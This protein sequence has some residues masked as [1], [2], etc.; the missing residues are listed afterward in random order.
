MADA[1]GEAH[2]L[3]IVHRDL[4][5]GNVIVTKAGVKLL[6]FGLAKLH[7]VPSA[8]PGVSTEA[9]Q[10]HP[11]TD[12]ATILG[13]WQYMSPEQLEGKAVDARTDIF[14][15]GAVLYEM[16][17]GRKAFAG[18][19]QASLIAAILDHDP[20]AVSTLRG[21]APAALDR[22]V[23][24]CLSKDREERWQT[25]RDVRRA[26][27]AIAEDA[28]RLQ[29]PGAAAGRQA[30]WLAATVAI[31]LVVIAVAGAMIWSALSARRSQGPASHLAIPLD[32]GAPYFLGIPSSLAIS[33]DGRHI[34]YS[35]GRQ[36]SLSLYHRTLDQP[37]SSRLDATDGAQSPFFSPDGE[38][39]G[40]FANGRLKKVR[41][42]AGGGVVTICEAPGFRGAT[43]GGRNTIVFAPRPAS[44]LYQVS[45]DGGTA[46]PLTTR[47]PDELSHRNPQFLPDG[48]TVLFTVGTSEITSWDEARIEA[49]AT[50]TGERHVVLEGSGFARYV[51]SGHL[52]FART[53]NLFALRFDE[54]AGRAAGQPVRIASNVSMS[55]G[56][57]V[58]FAVSDA[59]VLAYVSSD[60]LPFRNA[61]HRLEWIDRRGQQTVI[62]DE[63][64]G[65]FLPRVSP[66]GTRVVVQIAAP[67]NTLWVADL[68]RDAALTR[69]MVAG[70]V[71]SPVWRD[72]SRLLYTA[73]AA[74]PEEGLFMVPADG[75]Q[76]ERRLATNEEPTYFEDV[77]RDGRLALATR[78]SRTTRQDIWV[79]PLEGSASPTAFLHST[80][81]EF[82]A[83][84]S[85]DGRW[86]AYVSNEAGQGQYHVY[87]RA[88]PGGGE[89]RQV[90]TERAAAVVWA[91]SGREL[92]YRER[93]RNRIM[94][95][96]IQASTHL[97]VGGPRPLFELSGTYAEP[98]DIAPDG[99]RFLMVRWR[100]PQ[101]PTHISVVVNWF[102][103]LNRLAPQTPH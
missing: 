24:D 48:R 102:E 96:Q 42:G 62:G 58:E 8:A 86:L 63:E 39:V 89:R 15:F 60:V 14:A 27:E 93:E 38:W 31:A 34:V 36:G 1:L 67:S 28:A 70:D 82:G 50:D 91:P 12:G 44:G 21:D 16:L 61:A 66:G 30:R 92:F 71:N 40:F 5:P 32:T 56:A 100:E 94:A 37:I 84:L 41:L 95:V 45:A 20:P 79:I 35:A 6:D 17:T 43:W 22:I 97:V 11:L 47:G 88:F 78:T 85:P 13:T 74:P 33:P 52:V 69:V 90:S 19:S 57:N 68:R 77:S 72:D 9:P 103:E 81:E 87:L 3:G 26:L 83:R 46:Q 10:Q 76:R 65:F 51:R 99:Q 55:T 64:R 75:S 25:M 54:R 73:L 2:R 49:V 18:S 98:F 23:R 4:K 101:P 7:E 80:A 29:A 59:G 53:A